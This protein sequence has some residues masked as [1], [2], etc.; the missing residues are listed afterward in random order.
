MSAPVRPGTM[1][2][3][4]PQAF[5]TVTPVVDMPTANFLRHCRDR[6]KNIPFI[7]RNEHQQ[8]HRLH[9]P[10]DHTHTDLL[11]PEADILGTETTAEPVTRPARQARRSQ[12]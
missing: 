7:T 12:G 9:P 6:H 11:T 4:Q 10:E 3:Q 8:D 5:V 2:A 1:A